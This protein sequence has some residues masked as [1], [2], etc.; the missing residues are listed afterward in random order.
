MTNKT[1]PGI[2]FQHN[3][4][5]FKLQVLISEKHTSKEVHHKGFWKKPAQKKSF[6][7]Q[8]LKMI[9]YTTVC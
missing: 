8:L 3:N 7:F 5:Q 1:L 4:Q 6:H 2:S 9:I